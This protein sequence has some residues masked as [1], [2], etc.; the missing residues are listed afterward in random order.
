M[1]VMAKVTPDLFRRKM[2][3]RLLEASKK[4]IRKF[5]E[6]A[7]GDKRWAAEAGLNEL[8]AELLRMVGRND[9]AEEFDEKKDQLLSRGK[10]LE[11]MRKAR[12]PRKKKKPDPPT[13]S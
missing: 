9:L 8:T 11:P 13:E 5:E 6:A 2:T 1:Q 3:G 10:T 12:K 4:N 7:F